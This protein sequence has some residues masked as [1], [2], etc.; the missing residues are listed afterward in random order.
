LFPSRGIR[1]VA[2]PVSIVVVVGSGSV[3][4]GVGAVDVVGVGRVVTVVGVGRVVVGADAVGRSFTCIITSGSS[5]AHR[6]D[7]HRS[8]DRV[9]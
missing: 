4:G 9:R 3:D 7:V 5:V 8:P 6:L 1:A 2:R